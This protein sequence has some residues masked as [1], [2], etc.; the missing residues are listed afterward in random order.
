M[1]GMNLCAAR[2]VHRG[3][4]SLAV[5]GGLM[6]LITTAVLYLSRQAITELRSASVGA[7]RI[8][9]QEAA[10]AGLT[11]ATQ[12]L[13]VGSLAGR[14]CTPTGAGASASF[15][16]LYVQPGG[17]NAA[18]APVAAFPGCKLGPQGLTCS[19]PDPSVAPARST[20]SGSQ[21]AFTVAFSAVTDAA[22]VVATDAVRVTA[23]GCS[24]YAGACP[25]GQVP[26]GSGPDA[27]AQASVVLKLQPLL[28]SRPAAALTCAGNCTLASTS[29][30]QNRD[31]TTNGLVVNAGG[32]ISG[33]RDETSTNPLSNCR[34]LQGTPALKAN[35]ALDPTPA[36][37]ADSDAAC[38]KSTL[39]RRYFAQPI[40]DLRN[41]PVVQSLADCSSAAS[42]SA[43]LNTALAAGTRA[44]HLPGGFRID[45]TLGPV[46]GSATDPLIIVSEGTLRIT[47]GVT[48]HALIF[49][50]NPSATNLVIDN[51]TINGAVISCGAPNLSGS[52]LLDYHPQTM[53]SLLKSARYFRR[54][55]GSW[56]DLC[57]VSSSGSVTCR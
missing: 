56:T 18:L 37:V 46:V 27:V 28:F 32:T 36:A 2:R 42:C 51:A 50:Q 34:P 41:S 12:R 3:V 6:L 29:I 1:P 5:I 44:L 25:P 19:C 40:E 8:A 13:N 55:A 48:V 49:M 16:R 20:A 9:A 47:G 17:G 35:R 57:T 53:A 24:A 31:T 22:G 11:W 15:R 54:L 38:Q 14:D 33:C 23:T 52:F 45:A 39:L 43:S 30:V 26:G 4:A 21:A 7:A 10:E